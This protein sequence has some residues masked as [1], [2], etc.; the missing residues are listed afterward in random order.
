MPCDRRRA[1]NLSEGRRTSDHPHLAS[2]VKGEGFR[3]VAM[4]QLL[5]GEGLQPFPMRPV[6]RREAV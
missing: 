2:P 5:K 3:T 4:R 6:L 1:L